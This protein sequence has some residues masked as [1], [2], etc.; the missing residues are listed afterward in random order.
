M[1]QRREDT[2]EGR[3]NF[4]RNWVDY[5]HGFGNPEKEFWLGNENIYM[6]TNNQDYVLR[7]ELEDFDGNKK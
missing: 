1:I 7:V 5:K 3:E 2:K 4:T 6:L